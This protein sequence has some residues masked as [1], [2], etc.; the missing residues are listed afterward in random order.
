[1][2]E[3]SLEPLRDAWQAQWP[4]AL[5]L[6]SRYT[7][8]RDPDYLLSEGDHQGRNMGSFAQ[9]GLNDH[10]ITV[11]LLQVRNLGLDDFALEILAHEIGHHVYTPGNL[12]DNAFALSRSRRALPGL[13]PQAPMVLNLYEDLLI[14]DRLVRFHGLRIAEVYQQLSRGN[15]GPP[16]KVWSL[17]TRAY[18]LLWGLDPQ[19]L[20]GAPL[21]SPEEGDA[22]LI[23]RL[24]RV[25]GRDWMDGVAGFSALLYPYL[26][27][28]QSPSIPRLLDAV[29]AGADGGVPQGLTSDDGAPVVHPARDPR[30]VGSNPQESQDSSPQ[31]SD[32]PGRTTSAGQQEG[33]CRQPFQYGQLLQALGLKLSEL[34]IVRAYYRELA[35]PHLIP[36][37]T[38]EAPES[39]EPL[40]EGLDPWDIGS[41][42]EEVDWLQSVLTS[43]RIFPG[44]TTVARSWGKMS[45]KQ[46][47]PE[48]LDLDIYVDC[49]GSMPNPRVALSYIAL[50]GA[51]VMLS[52]LRAGARVQATLWSGAGQ[53]DTTGGFI[54]DEARLFAVLA[55]YLGGATAF[56]NHV[57]RDTYQGRKEHDRPVHI[58]HLS[59]EGID[60]MASPDEKGNPGM[61][62]SAMAL[63]KA[64]GGGSMVLNMH[65]TYLQRPFFVEAQQQGWKIFP[66]SDL[67]AMVAFAREFARLK[68]AKAPPRASRKG[69]L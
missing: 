9:I 6:W 23:A 68:Y 10:R 32:D 4:R 18:E 16:S 50:A 37:P 25:Y 22:Q 46:R 48:P 15:H 65:P 53:F 47:N 41:P 45:G 39:Q 28:D 58:L 64:R 38:R 12:T 59:D 5:A 67:A 52:A 60:T 29:H 54:R 21:K 30:V 36:F 62:L 51:V 8:L 63:E 24:V 20:G 57:L 49:S 61:T 35:L 66:V 31:D 42:L 26:K 55:G 19:S 40:M 34:D 33:Q 1:M 2:P 17:Y 14:N 69:A 44:L 7:R 13:E 3:E 27:E 43:P 56:P 11:S